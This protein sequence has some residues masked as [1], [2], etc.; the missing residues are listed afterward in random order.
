MDLRLDLGFLYALVEFFT[1]TDVPNGQQV[2]TFCLKMNRFLI[3]NYSTC[4]LKQNQQEQVYK[5]Q[6]LDV[7][8]PWYWL[9]V[10]PGTNMKI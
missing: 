6:K 4:I 1:Q 9:S 8:C 2:E 5:A 10:V 7:L 3:C